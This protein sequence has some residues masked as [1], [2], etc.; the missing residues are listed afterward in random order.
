[1]QHEVALAERATLDVL[2]REPDRRALDQ[3]RPER[4]GLGLR[5]LHA[6]MRDGL[7][8]PL[9]LPLELGMDR[10]SVGDREQRL[11]DTREH[12]GRDGRLGLRYGGPHD[13]SLFAGRA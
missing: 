4:E 3:Q 5:P 2:A 1:V 11:V 6:A 13:A 8:T 7:A 9:Q 10:E 12:V